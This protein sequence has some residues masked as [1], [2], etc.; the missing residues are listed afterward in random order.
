MTTLAFDTTVNFR[1]DPFDASLADDA[2]SSSGSS[3]YMHGDPNVSIGPVNVSLEF[4]VSIQPYSG[5]PGQFEVTGVS[6]YDFVSAANHAV[7]ASTVIGYGTHTMRAVVAAGAASIQF[8]GQWYDI[9]GGAGSPR[10]SPPYT[11]AIASLT[12]HIV[13]DEAVLPYTDLN[14]FA[15]ETDPQQSLGAISNSSVINL[16]NTYVSIATVGGNFWT[17]RVIAEEVV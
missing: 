2:G 13:D 11:H 3:I 6:V 15:A 14:P 8:D 12:Y 17:N 16:K 4:I 5:H 1:L 7:S 9:S 10:T